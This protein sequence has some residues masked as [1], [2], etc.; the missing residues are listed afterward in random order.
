MEN[1]LTAINKIEIR[2]KAIKLGEIHKWSLFTKWRGDSYLLGCDITESHINDRAIYN[3]STSILWKDLTDDDYLALQKGIEKY[4]PKDFTISKLKHLVSFKD[5]ATG[6]VMTVDLKDKCFLK[7][8]K[9]GVTK[10]IKHPYLFF[11][12]VNGRSVVPFIPNDSHFGEFL[13]TIIQKES[14]CSN[15]STF[16][17]RLLDNSHLETYI[18]AK[19]PFSSRISVPYNFFDKDV[20]KVLDER[21]VKYDEYIANLFTH[22]H[23]MGKGILY[24]IKDREDFADLLQHISVNMHHFVSLVQNY[25]YDT[26][27]LF[28]YLNSKDWKTNRYNYGWA[29]RDLL[30]FLADYARMANMVYPNGFEKY[31]QNITQAHD[32][33]V[34]LYEKE[35]IKYNDELYVK[36]I[37]LN[38]EHKGKDFSVIYPK[39]TGDIQSE[40]RLLCH[41]VGSYVD[42]VIERRTRILFMRSNDALDTPL[43]TIE[44][45]DGR[46]A[47]ARGK[48]N[49]NLQ[50]EEKNFLEE[51][52]KKKKL[53][54]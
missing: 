47:Q 7:T 23:D 25:N 10:K 45:R 22:H 19:V 29:Y 13:K 49:R 40:G 26:T 12:G 33:V 28:D 18:S 21:N 50:Y 5:N 42:S 31:P 24:R 41:C 3:D 43:I 2:E 11:K 9:K 53:T 35:K 34:R 8:N 27:K 1:K 15:L 36:T 46:I 16:L 14:S 44:I 37:D 4:L 20:R 32:N 6:E 39:S 48:Y 51:Y 54:L 30:G 38:F 52:A 17:I